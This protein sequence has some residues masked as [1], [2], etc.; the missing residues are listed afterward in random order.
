MGQRIDFTFPTRWQGSNIDQLFL[1]LAVVYVYL[2]LFNNLLTE[3]AN[4]L[5]LSGSPVAACSNQ[6]GNIR[7]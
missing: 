5:L 6:N 3:F 1:L 2:F 4:K 7:I